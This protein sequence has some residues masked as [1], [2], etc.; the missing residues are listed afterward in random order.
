M[1]D[2]GDN[3]NLVLPFNNS[4]KSKFRKLNLEEVDLII[5]PAGYDT[6]DIIGDPA[7]IARWIL[8][9]QDKAL[10]DNLGARIIA[11][12]LQRRKENSIPVSNLKHEIWKVLSRSF[13]NKR[14]LIDDY[15]DMYEYVGLENSVYTLTGVWLASLT[16]LNYKNI[17]CTEIKL[18]P[19]YRIGSYLGD[20]LNKFIRE[21]RFE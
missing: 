16:P 12:I 17:F 11:D 8:Y 6:P 18:N 7:G 15:G 9:M 4:P 14:E 10:L 21:S 20:R 2:F 3:I 5:D 13:Q 1:G 19:E